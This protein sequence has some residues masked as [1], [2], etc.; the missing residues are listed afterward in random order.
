M[1]H[2]PERGPRGLVARLL[3]TLA[4]IPLMLGGPLLATPAWAAEAEQ[5][6][7]LA[8]V[9]D[10]SVAEDGLRV[11]IQWS[12][13]QALPSTAKL[14]SFDGEDNATDGTE[15]FPKPGE[16]SE[17]TLPRALKAPW[18]TGWAQRLVLEDPATGE[19]LLTQPYDISLDCAKEEECHLTVAPGPASNKDVV[20]LSS[21]LDAAIAELEAQ[22]GPEEFNLV[23]KVSKNFPHLRGQVL[24]YASQ[25]T[26]V[27]GP[28][29]GPCLCSWQAVSGQSPGGVG[30]GISISNSG[31]I[32][33]GWNGPGAKHSLTAIAG[34]GTSYSVSGTS[35]VSLRLSC[36]QWKYVIIYYQ[37]IYVPFYGWIAVP[38][39][40]PIWSSCVSSC[41]ARF[42]HLGHISGDTFVSYTSPGSSATATERSNYVVDGFQVMNLSATQGSSFNQTMTGSVWS[43]IGSTGTVN[44]AGGVR[45][46]RTLPFWASAS[47]ANGHA[48]A[49]HGQSSCPYGPYGHAAVWTYGTSQGTPQTTSIKQTLFNYFWQW[50][51]FIIP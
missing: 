33:G 22:A 36:T 51:I 20:H 3:R 42:D 13:Q 26:K 30:Y 23:E 5:T 24:S 21:E 44:S 43:N 39:Y 19:E 6:G 48:I 34:T 9:T 40:A 1:P 46:A 2:H 29:A 12:D 8:T 7:P 16:V 18:E 17:V 31:G 41:A 28:L 47:V 32:I 45:A 37:L 27:R 15:V 11:R 38:I 4:L 49:I 25:L 35:Q 10:L 50:G 14:V